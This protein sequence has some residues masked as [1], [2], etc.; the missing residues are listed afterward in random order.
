MRNQE[1]QWNS[2]EVKNREQTD[3]FAM[4]D[5]LATYD[6]S[7]IYVSCD[8]FVISTLLHVVKAANQSD[9]ITAHHHKYVQM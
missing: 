2:F 8:L 7:A 9:K 4:H 1:Q 5:I 3:I 6:I